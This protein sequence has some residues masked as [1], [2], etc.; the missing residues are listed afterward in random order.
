MTAEVAVLN[1]TA[2]ALATDSA[3]TISAGN[4]TL[5]IFESA[6]KLFELSTCQPLGIMIYNGMQFLGVPL[7][8]VIKGFRKKQSTFQTTVEAAEAFLAH[9]NKYVDEAPERELQGAV[10]SIVLPIAAEIKNKIEQNVL[11]T[12]RKSA[13]IGE[14]E[15]FETM[16]RDAQ[17]EVIESYDAIVADYS[18]AQF[19]PRSDFSAPA[20]D[21]EAWVREALEELANGT[22]AATVA[23]IS[24]ICIAVLKSGF[25]S[26]S[27]TGLVIAGF[28]E[29]ERFPTLISY[30]IDGVFD[31]KIRIR[32]TDYCDID[33]KGPR[34]YVT[35]FAQKDMVDRFLHGLDD[36]LR[37]GITEYC[38]ST[39]GKISQ[40]IFDSIIIEDDEQ[41]ERLLGLARQAESA[42]IKNLNDKAFDA[43]QLNSR[44]EIEDMVEFMPKP[45]LARMAE[46]LI[47]LTSIKRKVSQ[48]M[49]TVGGPV[50]VAVI[51]KNDGFVWVKRKHYFPAEINSRYFDRRSNS[52]KTHGKATGETQ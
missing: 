22:D 51:S 25:I 38:E 32:Q 28:G 44:R 34:A 1:K 6:D 2:V 48:G 43:F 18:P 30:E 9:L 26:N 36:G 47:D 21:Y 3:V 31:G 24:N 11:D 33:R 42:F 29:A 20:H 8:A 16:V 49:E 19:I 23:K 35:P 45:E 27:R 37:G 13:K 46:A 4:Q 40:G 10:A 50:D 52:A 5:K 7:E 15:D 39:I 17:N 41:R 14:V 12:V